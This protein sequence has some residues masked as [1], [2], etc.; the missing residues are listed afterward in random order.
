M[1]AVLLVDDDMNLL[2]GL[3]RTLRDQPYELYMANSA[4]VAMYMFQRRPFDLV[5]V[6]QKMR[7]ISGDDLLA[8]LVEYFPDTVRIMLTGHADVSVM[9]SAINR[10]QVFRFLTK[11]CKEL[12]L[13]MAIR[14]GLENV[15]HSP[16]LS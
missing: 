4:E 15:E 9:K 2:R 8:W 11:P 5:V 14:D 16:S 10:G 6:D 12:E 3:Q 7:G 13:A 1:A